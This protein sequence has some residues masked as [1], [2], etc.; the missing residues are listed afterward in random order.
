MDEDGR[1]IMKARSTRLYLTGVFIV[2]FI[3]YYTAV[4]LISP[5]RKV[6]EIA[7]EYSLSDPGLASVDSTIKSDS[8]FISL[9]KT[10]SFLESRI[11]MATTDSLSLSVDLQDSIVT[12]EINGVVVHRTEPGHFRISK[13]LRKADEYSVISMLS[14]PLNITRSIATIKKEPLLLKIAPKDTSEYKPDVLPDTTLSKVVNLMFQTD[15]GIRIY[16]YGTDNLSGSTPGFFWFDLSDR[17]RNCY[18]IIKNM[19][20]MRVP[21]Y[22]PSVRIWVEKPDARIIYRAVPRNG[23]IALKL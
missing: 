8:A 17:F 9:V 7:K 18:E 21:D 20:R 1:Q 15:R 14:V 11:A 4:A 13:V 2:L 23:Q 19:L 16:I 3:V 12:L 5:V 10:K 22:H 6:S